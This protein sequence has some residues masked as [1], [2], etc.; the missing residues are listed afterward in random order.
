LIQQQ[1]GESSPV[2]GARRT[3]AGAVAGLEEA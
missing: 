2:L 1:Q 3:Q